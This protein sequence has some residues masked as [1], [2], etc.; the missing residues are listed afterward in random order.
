MHLKGMR[1]KPLW[2]KLNLNVDGLIIGL[3]V[4]LLVAAVL[5][6]CSNA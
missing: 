1:L 2:R 6:T 3:T 4:F 5:S